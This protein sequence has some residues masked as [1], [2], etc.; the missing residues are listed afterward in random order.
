MI[1]I[2]K[3]IVQPIPLEPF[4]RNEVRPKGLEEM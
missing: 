4:E 2:N 1:D 3:L